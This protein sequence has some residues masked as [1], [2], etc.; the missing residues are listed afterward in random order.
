M[1]STR[2][3]AYERRDA[4]FSHLRTAHL[5]A[6]EVQRGFIGCHAGMTFNRFQQ[7]ISSK[8][9]PAWGLRPLFYHV[10]LKNNAVNGRDSTSVRVPVH[11]N[12]VRRSSRV[13][14]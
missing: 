1:P 10:T 8:H 11:A 9:K 4:N 13:Q 12:T 14:S 7:L 6:Q 5:P 2:A 3:D